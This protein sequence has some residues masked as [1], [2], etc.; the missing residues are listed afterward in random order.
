[1]EKKGAQIVVCTG[2]NCTYNGAPDLL[3]ALEKKLGLTPG[4]PPPDGWARVETTQCTT[5]CADGP[6]VDIDGRPYIYM[7]PEKLVSLLREL[8][9]RG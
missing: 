8:K 9:R 3:K 5:R 2:L 6:N 1:M 7:E 4:I